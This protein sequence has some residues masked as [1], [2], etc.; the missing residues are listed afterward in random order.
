MIAKTKDVDMDLRKLDAL[1]AEKVMG[2]TEIRLSEHEIFTKSGHIFAVETCFI[3]KSSILS[4]PK[5]KIYRVPSYSTDI[6]A[7]WTVIDKIGKEGHPWE[8]FKGMF[9]N[10]PELETLPYR[11]CIAALNSVGES[12]C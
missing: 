9:Q 11:I 12:I 2:W 7:A 4:D 10:D 1:V 3:G 5:G 6:A 8:P